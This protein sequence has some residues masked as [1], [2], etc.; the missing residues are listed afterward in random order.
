M[1]QRTIDL[2]QTCNA[3][4]F[5]NHKWR[6]K[7]SNIIEKGFP[8]KYNPLQTL[9][10]CHLEP[11]YGLLKPGKKVEDSYWPPFFVRL[12]ILRSGTNLK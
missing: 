3:N 9:K 2:I 5:C 6:I 11:K 7:T 1:T 8:Y 12:T 10:N 4:V